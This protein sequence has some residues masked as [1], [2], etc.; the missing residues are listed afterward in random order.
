MQIPLKTGQ[1]SRLIRPGMQELE[2]VENGI[3][4]LLG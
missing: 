3:I 2:L 1:A 4:D